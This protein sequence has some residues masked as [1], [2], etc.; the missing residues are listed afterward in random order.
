MTQ[1]MLSETL[2]KS[3]TVITNALRLL[4]LPEPVRD[5]VAGGELS[6]GHA[7]V[8][9][10]LENEEDIKKAADQIREKALSVRETEALVR[11]VT[12]KKPRKEKKE[13]KN[14]TAYTELENNLKEKLGTKVSI[15]RRSDN[16]GRIEI[17]FYSLE[18]IERILEHIR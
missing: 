13:L 8:L 6:T 5:M 15:R 10:G 9:L 14:K 18:D 11:S 12:E 1:E 3:R 2:S 7:K 16:A 4:K 17:D